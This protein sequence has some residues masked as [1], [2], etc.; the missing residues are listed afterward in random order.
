MAAITTINVTKR[1]V[2]DFLPVGN[3]YAFNFKSLLNLLSTLFS[4]L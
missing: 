1:I 3:L 4:E 2:F